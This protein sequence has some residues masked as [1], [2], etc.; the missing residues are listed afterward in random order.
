MA[1]RIEKQEERRGLAKRLFA[2]MRP[3]NGTMLPGID[4]GVG[5]YLSPKG[6]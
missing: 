6:H 1:S 3:Q 5:A 2:Y 4:L